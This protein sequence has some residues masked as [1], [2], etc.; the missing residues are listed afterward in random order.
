[1]GALGPAAARGARNAL[2]EL[3]RGLIFDHFD[4]REPAFTPALVQAARELAD[5]RLSDAGLS[6]AA[7]AAHLHVS[8]RTL[9]R[10]FAILDESFAAY[11]R[12]RRLEEAARAL[13][14]PGSRLTVSQAA[15]RWHFTDGSHFVRAFKRQFHATPKEFVRLNG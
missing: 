5:A 11:I 15:T 1:V 10:A 14:A 12:R 6:P 4:D 13:L 2:H 8:V 9:Q 3:V 7:I